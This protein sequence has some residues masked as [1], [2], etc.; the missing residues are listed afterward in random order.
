MVSRVIYF[1]QVFFLL[2]ISFAITNCQPIDPIQEI[3]EVM[4]GSF[5]SQQQAKADTNYYDIRLHM[6]PIWE[7]RNSEVWLYV[8]QAAAW[9]LD[10]PYRQR[11]YQFVDGHDGTI[12]SIVYSIPN[13]LKYA[14]A[15]KN[16]ELLTDLSPDSLVVRRGCV[17]ILK[18][19]SPY[20]FSG[21][22]NEDDCQSNLRGASYATT[23]VHITKD[24]IISW[25][26]GFDSDGSQVWGATK[27]G[28]IFN[29]IKDDY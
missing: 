12:Q 5:S 7:Y 11:V 22:T 3:K 24:K 1:T 9:N 21:S 20:E 16:S 28:Y 25:D 29:R 13:P 17:V 18:R 19:T 15:W 26:R 6:V 14:G 4:T 8:E 10:E 27:G 23:E 2:L